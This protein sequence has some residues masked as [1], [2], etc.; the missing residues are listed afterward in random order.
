M[1]FFLEKLSGLLLELGTIESLSQIIS[2]EVNEVVLRMALRALHV[3][4][5]AGKGGLMHIQIFSV[6]CWHDF[7]KDG[8]IF[9]M[10]D[11]LW[12]NSVD[13]MVPSIAPL[14]INLIIPFY[15]STCN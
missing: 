8:E 10:D 13:I 1:F 5:E 11:M 7:F 15:S 6:G 9:L 3:I 4:I 14:P 12:P 2:N